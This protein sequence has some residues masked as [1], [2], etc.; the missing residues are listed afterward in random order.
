MEQGYAQIEKEFLAI[1]HGNVPQVHIWLQSDH[2]PLETIVRKP[3]LSSPKRLQRIMLR[4]QKYDLD[5]VYVHRRL[6]TL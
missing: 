3:L 2:E 6:Q 4:I 5:V 1:Q